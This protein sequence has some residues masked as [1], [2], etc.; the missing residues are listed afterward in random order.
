MCMYVCTYILEKVD[1]FFTYHLFWLNTLR[2]II[3]K[4]HNSNEY[5]FI[6][7]FS[8]SLNI[9]RHLNNHQLTK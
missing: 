5:S 4:T 2:G 6:V 1:G 8:I 7:K 3:Y 9:P